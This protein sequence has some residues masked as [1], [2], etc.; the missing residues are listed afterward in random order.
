M[1]EVKKFKKIIHDLN[2]ESSNKLDEGVRNLKKKIKDKQE[3]IMNKEIRLYIEALQKQINNIPHKDGL[4]YHDWDKNTGICSKCGQIYIEEKNENK[5]KKCG[6]VTINGGINEI[7]GFCTSCDKV[8]KPGKFW[9]SK[10][11]RKL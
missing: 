1:D 11:E 10:W 2:I 6:I 4:C 7:T 3:F 9:Y 8:Y 5:C